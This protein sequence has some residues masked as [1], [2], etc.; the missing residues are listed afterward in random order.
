MAERRNSG[1]P[2]IIICSL[3]INVQH[4][5]SPSEMITAI[6]NGIKEFACYMS[7]RYRQSFDP[8]DLLSIS[9][10][11]HQLMDSGGQMSKQELE[12]VAAGVVEALYALEEKY[13]GV[14]Y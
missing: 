6:S 3:R 13:T 14:T 8:A 5:K 11:Q 10:V 9:D 1:S 7:I 2:Y 12:S 4:A